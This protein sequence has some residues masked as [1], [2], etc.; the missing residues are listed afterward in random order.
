MGVDEKYI[1]GL[2]R[3]SESLYR[4]IDN[5]FIDSPLSHQTKYDD[6]KNIKEHSTT[7]Q[8]KE[9]NKIRENS[10]DNQAF[11]YKQHSLS[12]VKERGQCHIFRR[13]LVVIYFDDSHVDV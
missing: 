10:I 4:N 8:V 9:S 7:L 11:D 6:L 13:G 3:D 5:E 2:S 12:D 1:I